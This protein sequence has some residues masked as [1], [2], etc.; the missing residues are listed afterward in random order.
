MTARKVTRETPLDGPDAEDA[1]RVARF[2]ALI[3]EGLDDL[4]AG[5]FIEV[6]D[7]K[8]WLDTLGRAPPSSP[9]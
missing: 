5:R 2:H 7:V 6:T 1:R 4:D 3:Q 8:T 9:S